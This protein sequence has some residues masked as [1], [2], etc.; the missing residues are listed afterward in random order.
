MNCYEFNWYDD[1]GD[2]GGSATLYHSEKFSPDEFKTKIAEA[3]VAVAREMDSEYDID[4]SD[5]FKAVVECLTISGFCEMDVTWVHPW[6]WHP[7]FDV[8]AGWKE[9]PDAVLVKEVHA[10]FS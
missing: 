7:L 4:V 5:V 3:C 10:A 8:D 1:D 6:T 2:R 9:K